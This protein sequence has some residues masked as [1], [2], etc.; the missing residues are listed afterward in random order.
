MSVRISKGSISVVLHLNYLP[1]RREKSALVRCTSNL[2]ITQMPNVSSNLEI[3]E[4]VISVDIGQEK[5]PG[6]KKMNS[7][8]NIHLNG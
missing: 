6:I 3:V 7:F 5:I 2:I 1:T 4:F 8:G